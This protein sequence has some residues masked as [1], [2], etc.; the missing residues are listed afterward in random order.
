MPNK[1]FTNAAGMQHAA[2]L[3]ALVEGGKS[4][5]ELV[6]V[7]GATLKTVQRWINAL[8]YPGEKDGPTRYTG[9]NLVHV[10]GHR[11]DSRNRYVIKEFSWN[12]GAKDVKAP[13]KMTPS[14]LNRRWREKKKALEMHSIMSS[15]VS[16][17]V[18]A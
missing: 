14:Q 10:S 2:L 6:Q 16:V 9:K 8:R 13:P 18:P 12:P 5:E 1:Y 11:M 4:Y 17:E 15:M 7:S 3:V